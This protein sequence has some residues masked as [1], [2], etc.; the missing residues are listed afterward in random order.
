MEI[1]ELTNTITKMKKILEES[2]NRFDWH[3]ESIR[4]ED[5][6]IDSIHSENRESNGEK[7]KW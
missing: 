2:D 4:F 6:S 7:K 3:K 5:R 1:L